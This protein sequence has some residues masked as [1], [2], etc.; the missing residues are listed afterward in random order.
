[1]GSAMSLEEVENEISNVYHWFAQEAPGVVVREE[2]IL[3]ELWA[4]ADGLI[5][6][7]EDNGNS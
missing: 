2:G 6:E 3:A 5:A 4:V 1:M 7:E